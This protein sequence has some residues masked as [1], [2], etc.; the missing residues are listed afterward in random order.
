M[1]FVNL[2]TLKIEKHFNYKTKDI[3]LH[4]LPTDTIFNIKEK[5]RNVLDNLFDETEIETFFHID[6][7]CGPIND[8]EEADAFFTTAVNVFSAVFFDCMCVPKGRSRERRLDVP[9]NL[10]QLATNM[11]LVKRAINMQ[12]YYNSF[13]LQIEWINPVTNGVVSDIYYRYDL[14]PQGDEDND[15]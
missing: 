9:E 7:K 11:S 14:V 13:H 3:D 15:N 12:T 6:L 10:K 1:Y 5:S 8:P 4:L 2:H